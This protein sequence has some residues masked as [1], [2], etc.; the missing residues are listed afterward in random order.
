MVLGEIGIAFLRRSSSVHNA[1]FQD[2]QYLTCMWRS[3]VY[4][5]L[6]IHEHMF[7]NNQ[8]LLF[9]LQ[10]GLLLII[11][12]CMVAEKDEVSRTQSRP[13]PQGDRVQ[14]L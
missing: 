8:I 3:L 1:F 4:I 10:V 11:L 14:I 13:R 6:R 9:L 2:V 5:G 7:I 12:P